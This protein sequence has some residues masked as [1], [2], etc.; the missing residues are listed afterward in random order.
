MQADDA[1]RVDQDIA[2]ELVHVARRRLGESASGHEFEISP[3]RRRAP[4]IPASA[5][6]H[7][8]RPI[9]RQRV[10]DEDRPCEFRFAD[11]RLD[12]RTGL[13]GYNRHTHAERIK[14]CFLL[15]Q[16]RQML[17]AGQSP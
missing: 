4:N 12:E 16:L 15:P 5:A 17:P 11:I 14:R 13:E 9:E 7:A 1:G 10:I 3:N 8:V 2:A 6:L